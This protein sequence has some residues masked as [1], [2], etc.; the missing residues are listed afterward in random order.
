MLSVY[1]SAGQ[2]EHDIVVTV[3]NMIRWNTDQVTSDIFQR[4]HVRADPVF[5]EEDE[6]YQAND[7]FL[8]KEIISLI[9]VD[10]PRAVKRHKSFAETRRSPFSSG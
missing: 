10:R 8:I 2:M 3:H 6:A 9:K 1:E 5:D 4:A 7:A